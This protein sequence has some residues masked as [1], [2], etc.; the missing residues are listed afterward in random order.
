MN[1]YDK[2]ELYK[3]LRTNDKKVFVTLAAHDNFDRSNISSYDIY[4]EEEIVDQ[5]NDALVVISKY[6]DKIIA[7][8]FI[9]KKQFEEFF[10][11]FTPLLFYNPNTITSDVE[12]VVAES[13]CLD[14]YQPYV[15]MMIDFV[16]TKEIDGEVVYNYRFGSEPLSFTV[17][18]NKFAKELPINYRNYYDLSRAILNEAKDNDRF[19]DV[20]AYIMD[21]EDTKRYQEEAEIDKRKSL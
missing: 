13:D 4:F 20:F 3:K 1:L 5:T 19:P 8:D 9:D 18:Y 2:I 15:K 6:I 10:I 12:K 14:Y 11:S 17:D 21:K 7:E 16:T